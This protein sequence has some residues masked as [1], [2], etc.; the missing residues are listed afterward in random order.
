MLV[1]PVAILLATV[2]VF[3]GAL[4]MLLPAAG[5]R[6]WFGLVTVP[7]PRDQLPGPPGGRMPGVRD[8]ASAEGWTA[9]LYAAYACC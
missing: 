6:P 2:V 7:R 1:N 4:W 5:W 9:A 8:D 3:G